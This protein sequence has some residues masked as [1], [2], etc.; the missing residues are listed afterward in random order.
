MTSIDYKNLDPDRLE[1]VRILERIEINCTR[2]NKP[3][4]SIPLDTYKYIYNYSGPLMTDNEHLVIYRILD[5]ILSRQLN[6]P[7]T[8]V[9]KTKSFNYKTL[10][11]IKDGEDIPY[12]IMGFKRVDIDNSFKDVVI[13]PKLSKYKYIFTKDKDLRFR[14]PV[15]T[16]P[17]MPVVDF[18]SSEM[19]EFMSNY[20]QNEI[21]SQ[22]NSNLEN[23]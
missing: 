22:K 19:P 23:S 17:S 3:I 4:L 8:I 16:N 2:S 11:I 18:E 21:N 6:F 5:E 13:T 20:F 15:N 14:E 12:I 1:L 9:F 10:E 7:Y